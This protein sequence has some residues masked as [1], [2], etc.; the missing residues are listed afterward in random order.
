[1]HRAPNSADVNECENSTLFTCEKFS[2]CNNTD[3]GF[4]CICLEGYFEN[5][6]GFCEGE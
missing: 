5:D 3:G 2:N 4:E 1:M 6:N